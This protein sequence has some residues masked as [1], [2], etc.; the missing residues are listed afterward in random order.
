MVDSIV[1]A[2]PMVLT[3][4]S[5][6]LLFI[7]SLVKSI[8]G[9]CVGDDEIAMLKKQISELEGVHGYDPER[10]FVFGGIEPISSNVSV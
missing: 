5:L 1:E 7:V 10:L 9:T 2:S 8:N 6:I 4:P 3:F